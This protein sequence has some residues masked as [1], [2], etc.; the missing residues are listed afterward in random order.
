MFQYVSR[1]LM[2]VLMTA[3]VGLAACGGA[4]EG[5]VA[6]FRAQRA[7]FAP[8]LAALAAI[9]RQLPAPGSEKPMACA[10]TL[11]TEGLETVSEAQ[12]KYL[13][14]R[15]AP[16][17]HERVRLVSGPFKELDS[18]KDAEAR[19]TSDALPGAIINDGRALAALTK[20][21]RVGVFRASRVEVGQVGDR[22]GKGDYAIAKPAEW[23]GWF[24]VF[25]LGDKPTLEAAFEIS[26]TN[27]AAFR[28]MKKPGYRPPADLLLDNALTR[29]RARAL[30][31]LGLPQCQPALVRTPR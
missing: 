11:P 13:L 2:F 30:E 25:T 6:K 22:D 24:F 3:G 28:F 7:E 12:L 23:A 16:P 18:S 27:D 14:D 26:G 8:T 4:N 19:T 29:L 15:E 21:K 1:R 20:T 9:E 17:E 5:D 31:Q 10:S